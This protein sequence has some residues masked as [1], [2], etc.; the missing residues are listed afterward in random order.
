[1]VVYDYIADQFKTK[2]KE[3]KNDFD[4]TTAYIAIPEKESDDFESILDKNDIYDY[5]VTFSSREFGPFGSIECIE[6][7]FYCIENGGD[8]MS[9]KEISD[10]ISE[11]PMTEDNDG[12]TMFFVHDYE[13]IGDS[14]GEFWLCYQHS[15][16]VQISC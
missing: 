6:Y 2:N 4:Y 7:C 15:L 12:R 13:R 14:I 9:N 1:M 8:V 11:K 16:E 3:M 10:F 5:E